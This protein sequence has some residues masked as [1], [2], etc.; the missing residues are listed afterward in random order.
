MFPRQA[1]TACHEKSLFLMATLSQKMKNH[2]SKNTSSTT[3][4]V[5]RARRFEVLPRVRNSYHLSILES[6]FIR[7][8]EP[9]TCKQRDFYNLK[10]YNKRIFSILTVVF[11]NVLFNLVSS[12]ISTV[13]YVFILTILS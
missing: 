7:S 8:C 2:P 10:L 4:V 1:S 6:L 12:K 3:L 9:K 5:L 13:F 11:C